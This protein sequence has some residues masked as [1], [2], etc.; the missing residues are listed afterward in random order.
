[1]TDEQQALLERLTA[2][3]AAD[4]RV[5]AAWLSGSLGQDAGDAWSDVDI[6]VLVEESDR[7]ACVAGYRADHPGLP[8]LVLSHVVYGRVLAAITPDWERFDL[9]FLTAAELLSQDGAALKLLLGDPGQ[10]PP[11]RAQGPSALQPLGP[12]VTEFL[13]VLG[14]APV[15][16]GRGEWLTMQQGVELLRHML[17]DLM[18][19][20]NEVP[21]GSRGVKRLNAFLTDDQRAWLE[22]LPPPLAEREALIAANAALARQFLARA[23]PLAAQLGAPWP[24]AFEDATRRH[25]KATLSLEI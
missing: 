20:E 11:P 17:I 25:L 2:A 8:P 7:A 6:V 5:R 12:L 3:L 15:A 1:M 10:T 9:S 13:R 22:A 23:K 18:L 4:P 21:P 19:I 16:V 24:T 14:L